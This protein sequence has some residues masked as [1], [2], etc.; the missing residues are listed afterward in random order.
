MTESGKQFMDMLREKIGEHH[1]VMPILGKMVVMLEP[2]GEFEDMIEVCNGVQV[3]GNYLTEKEA[4]HITQHMINYDKT[5]G[6][7]W[8][9]PEVLFDAVKSVGGMV[10]EPRKYNKWAL[11]TVMNMIH[12]DYGGVL[13]N[14][15]Q[16]SDYAKLA[17]RMAVAFITDPDKDETVRGY[18]GL[19]C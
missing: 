12:A 1:E 10:E 6:A 5:R 16:G 8:P 13:Q 2:M 17:Y 4:E 9:K 18:F 11:F 15:V 14:V 7:K 19:E 3:Y